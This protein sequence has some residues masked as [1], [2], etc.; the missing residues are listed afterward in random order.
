MKKIACL[1]AGLIALCGAAPAHSE[2]W[3]YNASLYG[4]MCGLEG[5]I[6]FTDA[7][8]RPFDASFEELLDYVDFAMA[9]HLEANNPRIVLIG[10]IAYF[11]LGATRDATVLRQP[12]TIDMDLQEWIFELGGGYR[13][14]PEV[15]LIL[16]GRYYVFDSGLTSNSEFGSTDIAGM[17][18]WG[19]IYAGA[20]FTRDYA[21][22]WMFSIRGDIG[23]G[24]SDF[25]W[26]G[27]AL[28]AYRFNDTISAGIGYRILSLDHEPDVEEGEYFLYD[29]TQNGFGLVVGFGL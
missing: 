2:D 19:D 3:N 25:A 4:W 26:F 22:N 15:D 21:E 27:N 18:K 29:V 12:V 16:A 23:A 9:T 7:L 28:V 8:Q 11:N 24:G 20:R 1:A 6:G 14:T 5:T 17:N 13:I 10:D